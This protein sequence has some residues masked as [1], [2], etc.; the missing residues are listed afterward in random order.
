[1]HRVLRF[2]QTINVLPQDR[3]TSRQSLEET[4]IHQLNYEHSRGYKEN[5]RKSDLE[6]WQHKSVQFERIYMYIHPLYVVYILIYQGRIKL[7][8]FFPALQ[9]RA[10]HIAVNLNLPRTHGEGCYL[11][12]APN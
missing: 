6:K 12:L 9:K 8:T 7:Q 1:M 2:D 4:S 3:F 11:L 5:L 10:K